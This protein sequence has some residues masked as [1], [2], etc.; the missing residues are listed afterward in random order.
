MRSA[1]YLAGVWLTPPIPGAR[2]RV[3]ESAREL[4]RPDRRRGWTVCSILRTLAGT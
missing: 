3:I 4:I 1:A 2:M